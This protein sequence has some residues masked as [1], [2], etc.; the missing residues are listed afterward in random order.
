MSFCFSVLIGGTAFAAGYTI[1]IRNSLVGDDISNHLFEFELRDAITNELIQTKRSNE[2]TITFDSVVGNF[3]T[4][5][6]DFYKVVEKDLGEDGMTYDKQIAYIGLYPDGRVAY[7]KDNTYKYVSKDGKPHPYHATNEELDGQA[8]MVFDRNTHTLIFFRDEAGK[9]TCMSTQYGELYGCKGD[10]NRIFVPV[11]EKAS[12]VNDSYRPYL[13]LPNSASSIDDSGRTT[14]FNFRDEVR[15]IIFKDAIRP[16]A[17]I[18]EWFAS[19]QNVE[20]MDLSKF[21]TSHVTN[22]SYS[23]YNM[24]RLKEADITTLDFSGIDSGAF[25]SIAHMFENS[26]LEEFDS[27]NYD[28]TKIS[29]RAAS[30]GIMARSNLR[31]LNLA[32]WTTESSSMEF[33]GNVCLEKLIIGDNEYNASTTSFG[34]PY[35]RIEDLS[36]QDLNSYSV[37]LLAQN[38]DLPGTYIRPSC[39]VNPAIFENFYKKSEAPKVITTKNDVKNPDTAAT[40]PV[41]YFILFGTL[42]AGI[43]LANRKISKLLIK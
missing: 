35:L 7:Q 1:Q 38:N 23:F 42:A 34:S 5:S 4:A 26:Q 8:Y 14:Y 39:N 27:R 12:E 21:D 13:E 17:A 29:G 36:V 41:V 19:W 9:Y 25:G 20:K 37:Y 40:T 31:Y 43:I 28:F 3:S 15:E 2:E 10:A 16:E 11:K 30:G 32:N 18:N 22:F 24:K 33:L 6:I